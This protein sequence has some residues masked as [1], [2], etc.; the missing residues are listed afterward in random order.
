MYERPKI[1]DLGSLAA[2]TKAYGDKSSNDQI[3]YAG[4]PLPQGFQGSQN[5][6]VVPG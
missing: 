5:G 4:S 1:T 6:V 3:I 2:L